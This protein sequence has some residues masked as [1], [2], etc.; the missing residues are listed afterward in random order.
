[1]QFWHSE[2]YSV[3]LQNYP[4]YLVWHHPNEMLY[5]SW[6]KCLP[7]NLAMSYKIIW[8]NTSKITAVHQNQQSHSL[9][10]IRDHKSI[11]ASFSQLHP[12]IWKI[13]PGCPSKSW[14]SQ[15]TD[16]EN[17]IQKFPS[18]QSPKMSGDLRD[19][20]KMMMISHHFSL[21]WQPDVLGHLTNHSPKLSNLDSTHFQVLDFPLC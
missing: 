5:V 17:Y 7:P 9:I 10:C 4:Q 16:T 8:E 13:H 14:A 6:I 18:F 12:G 11:S 21:L 15:H 2:D 19:D 3:L 1:M 20:N